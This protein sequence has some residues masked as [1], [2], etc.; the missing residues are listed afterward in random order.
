MDLQMSRGTELT[1]EQEEKYRQ[2]NITLGELEDVQGDVMAR[3]KILADDYRNMTFAMEGVKLG[4]NVMTSL[5]SLTA[6]LGNDNEKLQK[7]MAKVVATQQI[8]NT[9]TQIQNQ[10]NKDSIIM[11]NLRMAAETQLKKAIEAGTVAQ[12]TSIASFVSPG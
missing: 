9:I 5:Q 12:N 10:I 11:V 3:T 8:L 7:A 4:V 1:A 2:L 6:I